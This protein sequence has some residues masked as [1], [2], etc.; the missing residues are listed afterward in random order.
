[1]E[2]NIV[3]IILHNIKDKI[4]TNNFFYEGI[5]TFALASTVFTK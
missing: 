3:L 5:K 4:A 1:V 2:F